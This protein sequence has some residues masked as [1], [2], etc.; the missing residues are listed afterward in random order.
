MIN[1]NFN[2]DFE[3]G[4]SMVHSFS[5]IL[6]ILMKKKHITIEQM[7]EE[8][9]VNPRTIGRY[10]QGSSTPNL[11]IAVTICVVLKLDLMQSEIFLGALGLKLRLTERADCAYAKLLS[12]HRG[13]TVQECNRLLCS[14]GLEEKDWL[15]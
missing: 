4:C 13:L 6:K 5:E 11:R 3:L 14:Y 15:G 8:A 1:T 12:E 7:A 10:L 2:D 9:G